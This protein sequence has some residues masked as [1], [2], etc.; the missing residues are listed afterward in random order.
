MKKFVSTFLILFYVFASI[1]FGSIH[2]Y[3]NM[4]IDDPV[5]MNM[6]DCACSTSKMDHV[7]ET[8]SCCDTG[9]SEHPHHDFSAHPNQS[10][11]VLDCCS[12]EL[13]YH[14]ADDV[15][16]KINDFQKLINTDNFSTIIFSIQLENTNLTDNTLL[17]S[18]PLHRNLPL[19]I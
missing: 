9:D 15:V 14:Q 19:L 17:K 16:L 3:C 1:G 5:N 6:T 10:Q 12:I 2:Y 11:I 8:N 7:T 13:N 18:T 4:S